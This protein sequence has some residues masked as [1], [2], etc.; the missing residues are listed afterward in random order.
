MLPFQQ[1]T[2]T[3]SLRGV[4]V[5]G[6]TGNQNLPLPV[7][8]SLTSHPLSPS[9]DV[10]TRVKS[11]LGQVV[12]TARAYP[13]FHSIKRL[14]VFLLPDWMECQSIAALP[15]SIKFTGSHLYTWLGRHSESKGSCPR[16]ERNDPDQGCASSD[17]LINYALTLRLPRLQTQEQGVTETRNLCSLSPLLG[18]QQ[19]NQKS[20]NSHRCSQGCLISN[21]RKKR[22][23]TR[24]EIEHE[25]STNK[26][27]LTQGPLVFKKEEQQSGSKLK[28]CL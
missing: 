26:V 5:W 22:D 15:P 23:V 11:V 19:L 25:E 18:V 6:E 2:R 13:S 4:Y 16:T 14:E 1:Q 27:I 24:D 10:L 3:T 21:K 9:T 7:P 20:N 17:P 8:C 28:T 12:H